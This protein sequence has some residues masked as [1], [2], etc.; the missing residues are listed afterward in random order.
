MSLGSGS[1]SINKDLTLNITLG[2]TRIY[3]RGVESVK[4]EDKR[5]TVR[6]ISGVDHMHPIDEPGEG[7]VLAAKIAT[8][9]CCFNLP[10][11]GSAH[12]PLQWGRVR[13]KEHNTA[14]FHALSDRGDH[15]EIYREADDG[16]S[17]YAVDCRRFGSHDTRRVSSMLPTLDKAFDVAERLA[18]NPGG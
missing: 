12:G 14:G 17:G 8:L 13:I 4:V 18:Q 3:A 7:E 11:E 16:L 10:T 2:N 1:K 15:F 5:V 9:Q 6:T